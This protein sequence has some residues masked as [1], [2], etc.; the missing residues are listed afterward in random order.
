MQGQ[1]FGSCRGDDVDGERVWAARES[2]L[3]PRESRHL[4]KVTGQ[5]VVGPGVLP[6]AADPVAIVL[7][8]LLLVPTVAE[9][10]LT[11]Q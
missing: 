3:K 11:P 8:S 7:W 1:M 6:R 9:E 10:Q 4:P 2:T 5:P